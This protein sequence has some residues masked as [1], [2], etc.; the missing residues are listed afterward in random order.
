MAI[1]IKNTTFWRCYKDKYLVTDIK[2]NNKNLVTFENLTNAQK[3]DSLSEIMYFEGNADTS[4]SWNG[5]HCQ[6]NLAIW[7]KC[8]FL[9]TTVR[10]WLSRNSGNTVD[11]NRYVNYE[12]WLCNDASVY[13]TSQSISK[14]LDNTTWK[15]GITRDHAYNIRNTVTFLGP[16]GKIKEIQIDITKSTCI[17]ELG[18]RRQS[19]EYFCDIKLA[20]SGSLSNPVW[21]DEYT[22]NLGVPSDNDRFKP[23]LITKLRSEAYTSGNTAHINF[24]P[25]NACRSYPVL[26]YNVIT[27]PVIGP[28]GGGVI[29]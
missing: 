26:K 27:P 14:I 6:D 17:V 10:A 20:T 7:S 2:I 8:A 13:T 18:I 12:I 23:V 9:T 28:G 3:L 22:V 4:S 19:T 21:S 25:I 5:Y 1:D 24:G 16:T 11:K 15:V 29:V